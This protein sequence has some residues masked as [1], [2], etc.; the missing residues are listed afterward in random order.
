VREALTT[1][2]WVEP[3]SITTDARTRQVRF[4]VKNKSAFNSNE[5][6][7]ALGDRYGYGLTTLVGPTDP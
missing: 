7:R 1:L 2:P 6:K 4:T 3:D 5:L